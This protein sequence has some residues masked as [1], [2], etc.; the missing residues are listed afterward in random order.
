MSKNIVLF[1]GPNGSGKSSFCE[2]IGFA[3]LGYVEEAT[4]K[5]IEGLDGYFNNFHAGENVAPRLCSTGADDGVLVEPNPELLRFPIIEKNRTEGFAR[6]AAR[7]CRNEIDD[8][9]FEVIM[10]SA[11]LAGVPRW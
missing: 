4:A 2:A 8:M 1:L 3:L 5:R 6:L 9:T 7:S 11:Y 10:S